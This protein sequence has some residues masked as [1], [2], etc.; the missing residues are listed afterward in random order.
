VGE[1]KQI[2]SKSLRAL[3][4]NLDYVLLMRLVN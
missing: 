3:A 4:L 2:V 1:L